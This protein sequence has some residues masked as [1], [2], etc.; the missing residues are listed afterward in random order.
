[1][2]IKIS[3]AIPTYNESSTIEG[4]LD[5]LLNQTV[6]P[7]EILVSDG[8]S[9]DK[10]VEI[11]KKY[12]NITDKIKLVGRTG[13]CRGA[14]RNTAIGA[15]RNS[16]VALIDAGILPDKEWLEKLSA[17]ILENSE[18]QVVYGMVKPVMTDYFS[19]S[20]GAV[21]F[22][23][24][25]VQGYLTPSVAS[26]LLTKSIW[27]QAGKFPESQDGSYVVEDLVFLNRISRLNPVT[28]NAV[29]AIVNWE[30]VSNCGALIK[31]F[32]LYSCGTIRVGMANVWHHALIRNIMIIVFLFALA[33][34]TSPYLYVLI[35]LFHIS[36]TYS[37]YAPFRM[38]LPLGMVKNVYYFIYIS[39]VLALIDIAAVYGALQ[40]IFRDKMARVLV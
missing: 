32:S 31:R 3:V 40:W 10:T 6:P 2:D 20:L 12:M 22:A 7:D 36:R 21:M 23:K 35:L 16:Y 25:P 9:T 4:L 34:F 37:Y 1:M 33:F 39:Y 14:G 19:L 30:L 18:C 8:G 15:S 17:P 13:K 11:I 24:S 5:A 27:L 38:F 28:S 26:M 29:Y